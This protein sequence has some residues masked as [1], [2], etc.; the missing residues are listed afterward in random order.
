M[1]KVE[2]NQ[3]IKEVLEWILCII[4][5]IVIALL[6]RYFIGTPTVVQQPSMFPTLQEGQRL[7]LNR[8]TRTTKKMPQRG[9][10]IT[11][12]APSVT[13]YRKEGEPDSLYS[14]TI[15]AD[16]S[17]PSAKYNKTFKNNFSKFN[18]YVLERGKISYI[19]RVIAL[20]GDHVE[21]KNE[22]VYITNEEVEEY[23]LREGVVTDL[24]LIGVFTDFTVPE[25]TVF[26]L[27]DNRTQSTDSRAFGCIPLE[28]IE[29]KVFIRIW[30]LN[31]FGKVK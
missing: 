1:I 17:N 13:Y 26:V 18:Y 15:E 19:K 11:F 16:L 30:P 14:K 24:G 4:I 29:S 23:Y 5:A 20:P 2:F 8:W 10:I 22:K 21:I 6:V 25:N 7:W 3:K 12:E 28:K 27:G 9:D 31:L